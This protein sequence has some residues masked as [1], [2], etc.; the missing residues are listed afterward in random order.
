[1]RELDMTR[2]KGREQALRIYELIG[3][4][5]MP[6]PAEQGELLELY[7][8]GLIPYREQRWDEALE[9]YGK[10]LQIRPEDGA[11][12]LME[13]RCRRFRDNPPPKDWDGTFEDRRGRH[14]K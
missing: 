11:S 6:L 13:W 12:K 9:L 14:T 5:D 4:A 8:A 7:E 3:A 1:L 2:V 10:C